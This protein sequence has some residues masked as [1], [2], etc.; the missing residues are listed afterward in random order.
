MCKNMN[1][2]S[3]IA[4]QLY[5]LEQKKA[6]KKKEVDELEAQI[7]AL[8]EETANYMKKRQKN[9]IEVDCYKVLYSPY[10]KPQFDSKAFIANEEK[11]KELYDKYSKPI[12]M[13]RVTVKLATA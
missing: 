10:I 13:K 12:Q 8:K 1:E 2:L 4:K 6:K 9:E 7:K 3:G 5:E 11:G